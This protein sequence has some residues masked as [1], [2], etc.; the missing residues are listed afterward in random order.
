MSET[1][2]VVVGASPSARYESLIRLADAIR[3]QP[4][5]GNLFGLLAEELR[6]VVPFDAI[7]QFDETATK[8]N[9]RSDV[10]HAGLCP[11]TS[12]ERE[13]SVASWVHEHQ[14]P[15]V[16]PFVDRETR[17]RPS[18]ERMRILGLQ[19]MCAL[20]LSTAHRRLGSLVVS[21]RLPEAYGDEDVRFLALAASQIALAMDDAHNFRESQRAEERLRLL[22]D[23]TNRVVSTLDLREL[24]R[25]VCAGVA[26]IPSWMTPL[27][28]GKSS[29]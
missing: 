5:D 6:R 24:L 22:L 3:S 19:S 29:A 12:A 26:L 11:L 9:W 15:F 20:P 1:Q 18:M 28:V 2:V 21:S 16:V 27:P 23:L 14:E 8:V 4:V 25:E 10:P 7:A 13:E 17:C